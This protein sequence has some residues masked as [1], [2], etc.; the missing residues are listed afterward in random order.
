MRDLAESTSK[1]VLAH[2]ERRSALEDIY[3]LRLELGGDGKDPRNLWPEPHLGTN[4]SFDKDKVEN[5]LHEQVCSGLMPP[6][7]AQTGIA[8]NW[9]QYL[10]RVTG[11]AS[12]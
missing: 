2:T 1:L 7:D 10:P 5:W 3:A 12:K 11:V 4:N 9:R 6:Q 8:I